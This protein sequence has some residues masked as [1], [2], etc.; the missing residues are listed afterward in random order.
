MTPSERADFDAFVRAHGAHLLRVAC[1]LTGDAGRA[2]DLLQE[3][4]VRLAP[5]W[6]R[7]TAQGDP[8]GWVCR[9]MANTRVSWWRRTRRETLVEA[10]PERGHV[11]PVPDVS[12]LAALAGLPPRQRAVLSLRYLADFSEHATA[13]ALGCSTGTVKS[14]SAKALA[15]LRERM[16]S[17]HHEELR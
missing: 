15:K 4:L 2:E 8:T 13:S 5:R 1:G 10:V 14:Q 16:G 9:V 7:V 17:Y 6:R 12:L 3:A 11:P